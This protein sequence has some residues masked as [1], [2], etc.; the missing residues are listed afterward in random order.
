VDLR[1]VLIIASHRALQHVVPSAEPT[2]ITATR[3][4]PAADR[5]GNK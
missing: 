1:A 5:V 2:Y 4:T 3:D